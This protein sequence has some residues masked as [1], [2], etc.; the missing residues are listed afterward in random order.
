[1][2]N[3]VNSNNHEEILSTVEDSKIVNTV[4]KN[5]K[6][7]VKAVKE[8]KAVKPKKLSLSKALA[9]NEE[10]AELA[11]AAKSINKE[12]KAANPEEKKQIIT[13]PVIDIP[14]MPDIIKEVAEK[15]PKKVSVK[16]APPKKAAT[17]TVVKPTVKAEVKKAAKNIVKKEIKAKESVKK[18]VKSIVEKPQ[19]VKPLVIKNE[20]QTMVKLTLFVKFSTKAGDNIYVMGNNEALGNEDVNKALPLEYFNNDF[21]Y[22]NVEVPASKTPLAY[23][24]FIKYNDGTISY[25]WGKDKT[26]NIADSNKDIMVIDAWNYAGYYENSFYTEPFKK[27]FLPNNDKQVAVNPEKY[28]HLFKIK[29]PLLNA[30]ETICAIGDALN[31]WDSTTPVLFNKNN[32]E[33]WYTAYIDLSGRQ[34]PVTYKY[35]VYNL[36]TKQ[37]T[38]YEN[39][40]NRMLFD[41]VKENKTTIVHDGFAVLPNNTWKGAGVAIP[42]FSLKTENSF[43]VGEFA[44]IKTLVDWAKQTGLKVIQL[45]PIND[46]SASN[47]GND[48]YPYAAISAFALHPLYIN[49][50]QLVDSNT[51]E[52]YA[53]I[54]K[55]AAKLNAL[56]VFDYGAVIKIKNNF[57][58][59]CYKHQG[60]EILS[61]TGFK[62]YF[63]ENK[64]WLTPYA[65]FCYLKTEYGTSDFTKWPV[66]K[67]YNK[68]EVDALVKQAEQAIGFYYFVQYHLHL[69]LKDATAYAHKNG[70]AVKGD[71]PI[72]IYRY[73]ADAWQEPE[74]YHMDVQAGAPPDS[75]AI[76]GQNWGFPTYNWERMMEDGFAWWKRRFAQMSYYFD[77]FRIDHILGFFRIWSIPTH[78]VE[79]I[80]GH[81]VPAIPLYKN[82]F[83]EKGIWF[84]KTRYTRPYITAHILWQTFNNA[85][86]EV[87][88]KFLEYDGFDQYVFKKEYNTQRKVEAYFE[89]LEENDHNKF[90]KQG[91]YDLLSNVILFKGEGV[92]TYH[93]RI[94]VQSTSSFQSLEQ[95]TQQQLSVLYNNYFFERQDTFWKK[96]AL[97]KLPALKRVTNML[98]CGEDLGMV[99]DCVPDV[100]HQLGMLSLEI[101]RMPKAHIRNEFFNPKDAPYL[102]V[103]TPSTHDMSTVRGW[104]EEDREQSQRFFNNEL[105]LWGE[106]PYF[107]EPFINKLIVIQ[108]LYSPAMLSIFQLQ[109]LLGMD[110]NLRRNNPNDER[111]NQ[112]ADPKHYWGY[113]MHLTLEQLI[114]EESFNNE[115]KHMVEVSGRG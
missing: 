110:G 61:S 30:N 35:A 42:V 77:A 12:V 64:H 54:E 10:I 72:G 43:G 111:I 113:R 15:K 53:K 56:E 69:Q 25:D 1:M 60:A 22:V 23:N 39:G 89:T 36:D 108:H 88:E 94:A 75:F 63:E 16:K 55:E 27:V 99:P 103:V 84:D 5:R 66:Y 114:K 45:L 98:T 20:K 41:E 80:M 100:M 74:L 115:L 83:D 18:E 70:V 37:I 13:E 9:N 78:A 52:A 87:K 3:L 79:G 65:A 49:I 82:E 97:Q 104:W 47:T 96:Q 31:G 51:K 29:A 8:V 81:F 38:A 101:Q 109:D 2:S 26:I 58:E 40:E 93:F 19:V 14:V 62:K 7:V 67:T 112:P 102:S 48:S 17:K 107:C 71:L 50:A 95:G 11:K 106:A 76:K 21:W 46:T 92:D 32:N 4:S 44:D 68:N 105:G 6:A 34:L 73:G 57:L 28:T 86:E 85:Q 91:L 59:L 24:Y 90:I 33:D